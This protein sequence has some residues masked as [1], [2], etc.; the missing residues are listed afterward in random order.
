[1]LS[2]GKLGSDNGNSKGML[3]KENLDSQPNPTHS[4]AT[5]VIPQSAELKFDAELV[6]RGEDFITKYLAENKDWYLFGDIPADLRLYF[7]FKYKDRAKNPLDLFNFLLGLSEAEKIK[8]LDAFDKANKD[9]ILKK[10]KELL[11]SQPKEIRSKNDTE[12]FIQLLPF[13]QRIERIRYFLEAIPKKYDSYD[14]YFDLSE[15]ILQIPK[16]YHQELINLCAN[17]IKR[18]DKLIELIDS[19]KR[20]K[21][22]K[23]NLLDLFS[24]DVINIFYKMVDIYNVFSRVPENQ[25]IDLYDKFKPILIETI[26]TGQDLKSLLDSIPKSLCN[27]VALDFGNVIYD[28]NDLIVIINTLSDLSVRIQFINKYVDQWPGQLVPVI[29]FLS[30]LVGVKECMQFLNTHLDKIKDYKGLKDLLLLD[31]EVLAGIR[32]AD[33]VLQLRHLITDDNKLQ[34][35]MFWLG[36]EEGNKFLQQYIDKKIKDVKDSKS[37]SETCEDNLGNYL[38]LVN[39]ERLK[40]GKLN[41]A[42]YLPWQSSENSVNFI[43]DKIVFPPSQSLSDLNNALQLKLAKCQHDLT[44]LSNP[45]YTLGAPL[46][47]SLAAKKILLSCAKEIQLLI[48]KHK[49]ILPHQ[50]LNNGEQPNTF[51]EAATLFSQ[52]AHFLGSQDELG[53][54]FTYY[55]NPLADCCNIVYECMALGKGAAASSHVPFEAHTRAAHYSLLSSLRDAWVAFNNSKIGHLD[56]M[57]Q[58]LD[59]KTLLINPELDGDIYDADRCLVNRQQRA[60][61]IDIFQHPSRHRVIGWDNTP[62]EHVLFEDLTQAERDALIIKI[63]SNFHQLSENILQN[64][65]HFCQLLDSYL[66]KLLDSNMKKRNPD[67]QQNKLVDLIQQETLK[68]EFPK[69]ICFILKLEKGFIA[70]DQESMT[71]SE[72]D[73]RLKVLNNIDNKYK[74]LLEKQKA[75]ALADGSRLKD[76]FITMYD[77]Y[78]NVIRDCSDE[79]KHELKSLISFLENLKAKKAPSQATMLAANRESAAGIG[80]F[81]IL[82]DS[83]QGGGV[84]GV[85]NMNSLKV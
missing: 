26:K 48:V 51:R 47:R 44:A 67:A 4:V 15:I 62:N 82:K 14:Y 39:C 17:K 85:V 9:D 10:H 23:V 18:S 69:A 83:K 50:F 46:P 31:I 56:L 43:D 38:E 19:L 20:I 27:R 61:S 22:I 71:A 2:S 52:V 55:N 3:A 70:R 28:V 24:V 30:K 78:G 53:K 49:N 42:P 64:A 5:E 34:E 66:N 8:F 77:V 73:E 6:A 21:G 33:F 79:Y 11:A 68:E 60:F 58:I 7:A 29:G 63:K 74:I 41:V 37:S 84:A 12:L 45:S 13:E 80:L 32:T 81:A 35:V 54:L 40:S 76:A 75:V 72:V 1:M 59:G 25:L 16:Q 36:K 65:E 57:N